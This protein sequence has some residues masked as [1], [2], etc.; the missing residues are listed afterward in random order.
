VLF[1]FE[2]V[3][4]RERKDGGGWGGGCVIYPLFLSLPVGLCTCFFNVFH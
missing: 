3:E 2:K 1:K 4:G